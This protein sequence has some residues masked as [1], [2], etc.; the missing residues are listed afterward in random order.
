[1]DETIKKKSSLVQNNEEILE[2]DINSPLQIDNINLD[3]RNSNYKFINFH[4]DEIKEDILLKQDWRI[5]KG[6][7]FWDGV[8]YTHIIF[9]LYS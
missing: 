6:G 3:Y 1:M 4:F 7:I 8:Y 9:Y 5:G 2:Y